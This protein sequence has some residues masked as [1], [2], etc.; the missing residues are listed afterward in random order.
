VKLEKVGESRKCS[1]NANVVG[2]PC[3]C[4]LLIVHRVGATRS[5]QVDVIEVVL[6]GCPCEVTIYI[7]IYCD[8]SMQMAP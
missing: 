8:I 1:A 6:E 2:E 4:G 3:M 5:D 7:D